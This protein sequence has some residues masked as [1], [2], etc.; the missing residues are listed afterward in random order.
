[1][2]QRQSKVVH[3]VLQVIN[4]TNFNTSH[5]STIKQQAM[6]NIQ[7]NVVTCPAYSGKFIRDNYAVQFV[8]ISIV[9]VTLP[10]DHARFRPS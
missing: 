7:L 2:R 5:D 10:T 8:P 4:Q 3:T 1:M 6:V 9:I